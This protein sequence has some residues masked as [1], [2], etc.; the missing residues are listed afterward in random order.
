MAYKQTFKSPLD[1]ANSININPRK[2]TVDEARKHVRGILGNDRNNSVFEAYDDY[3]L[4]N[5]GKSAWQQVG[6]QP[7]TYPKDHYKTILNDVG[8][9][10]EVAKNLENDMDNYVGDDWAAT[11]ENIINNLT[12]MGYRFRE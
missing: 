4:R 6:N 12:Q 9:L 5:G 10:T 7:A 2:F 3:V 11:D 1:Q 8:F